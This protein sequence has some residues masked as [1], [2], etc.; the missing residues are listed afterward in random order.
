MLSLD[1]ERVRDRGRLIRS[2]EVVSR[3]WPSF[4]L[5]FSCWNKESVM[6]NQA[7]HQSNHLTAAQASIWPH[8]GLMCSSASW[9]VTQEKSV[10]V[11]NQARDKR[12]S[13]REAGPK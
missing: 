6:E 10:H 5:S 9:L 2:P 8:A 4:W 7:K 11:P 13:T 3:F 12:K 1:K